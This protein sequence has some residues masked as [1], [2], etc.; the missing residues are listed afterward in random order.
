M[1]LSQSIRVSILGD[2]TGS[3]AGEIWQ[4]GFSVAGMDDT[5]GDFGPVVDAGLGRFVT[6][7][8]AENGT[9]P[10]GT[11][12]LGWDGPNKGTESQ[13]GVL[14][15]KALDL[16]VALKG[17][18]PSDMRCTEIRV[19]AIKEDGKV[20]NG[21]SVFTIASPV[22]GTSSATTQMPPEVAVV[23]S[24]RT[25]GRGP[26]N[27]GRMYLPLNSATNSSGLIASAAQTTIVTA[28]KTLGEQLINVVPG[29]GLAV[30]HQAGKTY[31]SVIKVQVGNHWDAQRRR[32]NANP[33][34]RT[35]L[36]IVIP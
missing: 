9:W 2:R 7:A 23:A 20:E 34:V 32:Q 8:A 17:L 31:S 1:A 14:A 19:S 3:W 16:I 10:S 13:Q 12:T 24:L 36:P 18:M 25:G 5:G 30:V 15:V 35:E 27:R 4:T 33:E 6:R 26:R 21:A 11:Y 29:G 22:V 28:V